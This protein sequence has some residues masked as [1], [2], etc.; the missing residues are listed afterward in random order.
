MGI[1]SFAGKFLDP[2]LFLGVSICQANSL[3]PFGNAATS[4][5]G[6]SVNWTATSDGRFKSNVEENVVGLDF[7]NKLRPVTYQMDIHRQNEIM[8]G[9]K[10]KEIGDWPGKFDI[11][12]KRI[13]VSEP[14]DRKNHL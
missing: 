11:E 14:Q 9:N 4:T 10:A 12:Q 8:Y 13:K 6:G 3:K 2:P 7:I 5:I 1:S